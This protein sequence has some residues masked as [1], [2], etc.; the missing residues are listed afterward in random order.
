MSAID[1]YKKFSNKILFH[2]Q[3]N[4]DFVSFHFQRTCTVHSIVTI[5]ELEILN[6]KS[7]CE[8]IRNL[9]ISENVTIKCFMS[10]ISYNYFY[11]LILENIIPN[12]ANRF[13]IQRKV[14]L[15]Q[16]MNILLGST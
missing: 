12:E 15:S 13:F 7:D 5:L 9:C 14:V 3:F 4:S 10:L 8:F 2:V 6:A 1:Y 11:N 16:L